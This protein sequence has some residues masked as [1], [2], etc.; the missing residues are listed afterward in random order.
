[1]FSH[2]KKILISLFLI[3]S[4]S[5]GAITGTA[6]KD[7]NADGIKQDGEP[8]V[9][10]ITVTAYDENDIELTNVITDENGNY[11]LN[12]S[13]PVRLEF[14]LPESGCMAQSGIDF[15]SAGGNH[16]ASNIQFASGDGKIVRDFAISYPLDF[17]TQED[18]WTFLPIM[19]NGDPTGGDTAGEEIALVKFKYQ[20]E[21]EANNSG[22][23]PDDGLE[24]PEWIEL[25]KQSQIGP[26]HGVAYSREGRR[27]FVASV[28]RR[29][30]GYGPLGSGGIYMINPDVNS[31]DI[32][33]SDIEFVDLDDLG[34]ATRGEGDYNGT[35]LNTDDDNYTND[36]IPFNPVVGENADENE[37]NISAK[38]DKPNNDPAAYGQ[39]GK[40]G[41]GDI[42]IGEE[43]RYLYV[44]N[45][46]DRKL[47]RIDLQNP[48]NPI[49]PTVSEITNTGI[50]DTCDYSD[51]AGEYRPFGLKIYRERA[52]IGIVCSGQDEKG[53]KVADSTADM[54]GFVYSF[55]LNEFNAPTWQKETEWTF[56]YRDDDGSDRPWHIWNN[57]W[58]D[59]CDGIKECAEP[60]ISDIEFNNQGDL[61]ISIMDLHAQK[62]GGKNYRLTGQQSGNPDNST[63]TAD[64]VEVTVSAGDLIKIERNTNSDVCEYNAPNLTNEFYDDN[65]VHKESVS[66]A[67]SGHHT[68]DND[69]VLSTF[70]DPY[71]GYTAG[72][73]LLNNEDGSQVSKYELI[74]KNRH[75]LG[76]SNSLGDLEVMEFVPPIEVGN[77][78]WNDEDRDGIQ[79][80]SESGIADVKL[81]LKDEND[82]IVGETVTDE[83]GSYV[84]NYTNVDENTLQPGLKP[85]RE[86]TVSID[87]LQFVDGVG[88]EGSVLEGY[89]LTQKD[90]ESNSDNSDRVDSDADKE[91]TTEVAYIT[92]TTGDAGQ[93]D[94]SY[95]IG[96]IET[97]CI[98]DRIWLDENKNGIQD[99]NES[100]FS[101]SVTVELLDEDGDVVQDANGDDVEPVIT[102]SGEY[103]FCKLLPDEYKIKVTLPNDYV[104]TLKDLGEDD[105]NDS[106][107]NPVTK[108]SDIINLKDSNYTIDIGVYEEQTYCLGDYIWYDSN[109]NGIQE[110][111]ESGVSGVEI[112]LNETN[113]TTTTD[114]EGKY[115]F[116]GLKNG[117]YS[118][119]LDKDTLPEGYALT[120][121]NSGN[122][123]AIDSDINATSGKSN[124]VIIAD[125]NNTTLDGGIYKP[126]Y[127][128][129]DYIWYDSNNDGIQG[130][131]ELGVSGVSI[132]LNE[133]NA[134]TTTN[135]SGKYEFC[136]LE[137]GEYS[138]TVDKSTLPEGYELTSKNSGSDDG[139]DSDI[140][141]DDGK[142][143]TVTIAD[144]NNTTLDGGIYKPTYCLGDYIWYDN[145]KN[146]IQE[147]DERGVSSVNIT[148][149]ETNA[150]TTTDSSGKYEFCE[151]ENG[152][153]SITVDK[154]TLP[155]GY[156]LTTKNS[157][158]NDTVDSD[159]DPDDGISETITIQDA[160]NTTLDGGIYKPEEEIVT[161]C[162]GDYIWYDSN[163]N[164]IQES[165]ESGVSGVK[166]TL[167]QNTTKT[168]TTDSN[169]YYEICGLENGDYSITLDK[170]TLPEGYELTSKNSGSDDGVDSDIDPDDG[171]SD[172]VTIADANNTTLDA[173]IY[174]PTYCLGDY[175]WYDSN[176]NGIQESDER[177]ISWVKITLNETGA[178][179]ITNSS[180]QYEFC[181][182][183]NGDYSIT[184]DK[185]TLPEG[186]E[187]TS[188]NSG[189][190]DGVDSD[191]DPDS[192][193]SDTVTIQDAN[194]TT[195]D[196]GVYKVTYC[197][198][199][200]IWDDKNKN[201]IQESD[202]SGVSGVK[203]I[204]NETGNSMLTG[205]NGEY[206]FCELEDGNY[207]ITIDKDT[208]P[209]DYVFTEKNIG[210]NDFIDSDI[211]P[212]NGRS[213]TVLISDRDNKTLD[214]GVYKR[215]IIPE[216]PQTYCLGDY[217]WFDD[218]KNGIQE[219]DE[220][221]V[222]GVSI[223]LNK[224]GTTTTT[225]S[226]GEYKFCEL[227]NGDYSIT[228]DTSTLPEGYILTAKNQGETEER[229]SDID[230]NGES[231]I[232][233][234]QDSNNTTL[235]G[236]IY[237]PTYCL[238]D[239][240]WYD[241]NKNG[242]QDS[243]ESGVSGVKI[244]LNETGAETITNS[245]GY[246]EFCELVNGDYSITLDKTTLPSGYEITAQNRGDDDTQDSDIDSEGKSE[247]VTIEDMDIKSLD[248]GIY[249]EEV[250]TIIEFQEPQRYYCLGDYIW[251]DGNKNG[252]QES[253]ERGVSGV[254]ITLNETGAETITNSQG[255]YEFCGLENG[256]YSIT[257]D[258]STLPEGYEITVQN[259]GGDDTKDSDIDS[260]GKSNIVSIKDAD[261]RSLDGG[262]YKPTYC[263]GDYIWYDDN[264]NGIQDSDEKG[265]ADIK[266]T[267]NQTGISTL[268]AVDGTYTFCGLENGSYSIR[269][270]VSTLP[271]EYKITSLNRG[272]DD[273]KDN[274]IDPNSGESDLVVIQ[275][276]DNKTLDGGICKN[277][278]TI[279]LL[280][281]NDIVEA[282]TEDSVTVISVLE[283]DSI[284]SGVTIQLVD[285]RDGDILSNEVGAVVG[286]TNL[287]TTNTIY[288][289]GEGTWSID[290]DNIVFT[291]EDGFEGIP[292]PIYYLVEDEQGNQSNLA[293]VAIKTN[294]ICEPYEST[295]SDSVGSLNILSLLLLV[296][297]TSFSS[298]FFRK[299]IIK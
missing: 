125:A 215:E 274:D 287:S 60:L 86:Y 232:I 34:F 109:K 155:D 88:V 273:V 288:V 106:D 196:G 224:I 30:A 183:E 43:G 135:S 108:E 169:G 11:I 256:D 207:S 176:N 221:G 175:I 268:T 188:K 253:D 214:C 270:D 152:E 158:D 128:L 220:Y 5:Y 42:D 248:G 29:H 51:K 197:L 145:N 186:Y 185:A 134:T 80:P 18:P 244:T 63:T 165:D 66:G 117:S 131:D 12:L 62:V 7:Y 68:S 10:G 61:L 290:G 179:T 293:Q 167:D 36:F 119:A 250:P 59:G 245:Q 286:G 79:D 218:N 53:Y 223:T 225:D 205:T 234:I 159:I 56:D 259:S 21:G 123:D 84:F 297:L 217:I 76:K 44:V 96:L 163:N 277:T 257:L 74:Y 75:H 213:D 180:G 150:T 32:V 296:L 111:D 171:K 83:N 160:N 72:V 299:E 139:V 254:G 194:N 298:L 226:N 4:F 95:D 81:Y 23:E 237:K 104:V 219:S 282:N 263:L 199:D 78:V 204:L 65:A 202:E 94:H 166:I 105:T 121:Q 239:Y 241:S 174:K 233:T 289:E 138:I 103:K 212:V 113:E 25:A 6:F 252:V 229:D 115:Q 178:T 122:D 281:D 33:Q 294:C 203:V 17:S 272:D 292:T 2:I 58:I 70:L 39:V 238:G 269:I 148:L 262:I 137:N 187:L 246:Y 231:D 35:V 112:T 116:C 28:L 210:D 100:N 267:L 124:S 127:C 227:E 170:T 191:I 156:E 107:I 195:L 151:L 48:N 240:I 230:S 242:I 168:D 132:T 22:K 243:E 8:G 97:Y 130:S 184:I 55:D 164:G 31:S 279:E 192:G 173:G 129:G 172:T 46:Y 162:L 249:R 182:L 206:E 141:P 216:E 14:K 181:E 266:I 45:L 101:Q 20:N 236:G 26:T 285:I 258:T 90:S 147:S 13:Q 41:L 37:R 89:I 77:R 222:E 98:G 19:V 265:V 208:L 24:G 73:V 255:Y 126:T 47:Y 280:A 93:N 271:D 146:G 64:E 228:V 284:N 71:R 275:D 102:N 264:Q 201:G 3:A 92:F 157:G 295:A 144:A 200:Y 38:K 133:T 9:K 154:S 291:P 161:Y 140:D 189:S 27:V 57:N 235:D 85:H 177:G 54:K 136:E 209:T 67:L 99:S 114:S 211:D 149:N 49:K 110:R 153:Y 1:M 15:P 247:R 91:E 283:N 82:I 143:D 142:S 118:I 40:I 69:S 193:V 50:P 87:Q 260:E 52:Y 276:A 278:K 261:N 16:S 251:Y 190:D 198:G 120:Y